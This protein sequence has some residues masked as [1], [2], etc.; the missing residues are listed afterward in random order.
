M[1]AHYD[2]ASDCGNRRGGSC[3]LEKTLSCL[4]VPFILLGWVPLLFGANRVLDDEND[5][6]VIRRVVSK[7]Q[8]RFVV[9]KFFKSEGESS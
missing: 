2:A 7:K 1:G 6:V 4:P 5:R 8:K 3:L 9:G